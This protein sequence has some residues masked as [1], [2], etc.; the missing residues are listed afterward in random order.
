MEIPGKYLIFLNDGCLSY[1]KS[2]VYG[3][4][5]CEMSDLHQHFI[6]HDIKDYLEYNKFI[7]K[8]NDGTK[9][10]VFETDNEIK[11]PFKL[12]TPLDREGE[13]LTINDEGLSIEPIINNANQRFRTSLI[14]SSSNCKK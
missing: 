3:T 13:A 7:D 10:F 8:I 12:V 4:T 6:I 14:P 5:S 11:Y 9:E 1:K 2:G